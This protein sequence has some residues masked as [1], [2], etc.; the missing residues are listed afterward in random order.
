MNTSILRTSTKRSQSFT[1]IS[2][3]YFQANLYIFRHVPIPDEDP[4][5]AVMQDFLQDP[6][7][8]H[9]YKNL[10]WIKYFS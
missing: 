10:P 6:V 1:F 7:L 8:K 4:D 2:L 9:T 3:T 5:T